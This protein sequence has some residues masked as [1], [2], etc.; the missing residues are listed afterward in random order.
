[1]GESLG[2]SNDLLPKLIAVNRNFLEIGGRG[3]PKSDRIRLEPISPLGNFR[4][5]SRGGGQ[6]RERIRKLR[7]EM[8]FGLLGS[9]L[10]DRLV[11]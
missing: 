1:M 11:N 7:F 4:V 8:A 2:I 6:A 10:K 9:A 5:M 3:S